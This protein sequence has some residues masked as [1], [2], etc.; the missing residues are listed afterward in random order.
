MTD[1]QLQKVLKNH[2]PDAIRAKLTQMKES[3]GEAWA[4]AEWVE[5]TVMH[6]DPERVKLTAAAN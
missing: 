3:D 2:N 1:A 4:I 6:I 5:L